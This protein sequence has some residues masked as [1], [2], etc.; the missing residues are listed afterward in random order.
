M[1]PL[2]VHGFEHLSGRDILA[3]LEQKSE[4]AVNPSIWTDVT[5]AER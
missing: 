2:V 4:A 1:G 5:A 3:S